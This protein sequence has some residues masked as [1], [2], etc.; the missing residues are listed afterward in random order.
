MKKK[1]LLMFIAAISITL[2]SCNKED[3]FVTPP[4]QQGKAFNEL[5]VQQGFDWK[6]TKSYTFTIK[7]YANNVLK[8]VSENNNTTYQSS[9]ISKDTQ[10]NIV[11]SIPAYE[12]SVRL[13]YMGQDILVSLSG[14]TINYTFN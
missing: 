8:I 5:N 7:G 11:L 9:M 14:N 1:I 12:K 13:K 6:T 2:W 3:D 4:T 10:S